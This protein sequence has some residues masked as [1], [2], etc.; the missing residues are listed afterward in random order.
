MNETCNYGCIPSPEYIAEYEEIVADAQ[1]KGGLIT[2]GG[3]A[4]QDDEGMGRFYEP[5]I[6]ANSNSGMKLLVQEFH[7]PITGLRSVDS[8]GEASKLHNNFQT[9]VETS[10]F[11]NND[12]T[13]SQLSTSLEAGVL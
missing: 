13:V 3:Y 11:T 5:T 9:I 10:I 6:I 7:G 4:N 2:I 8:P 12:S 1:S